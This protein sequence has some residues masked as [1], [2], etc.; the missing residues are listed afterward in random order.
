ME[1]PNGYVQV[2]TT[3]ALDSVDVGGK[4]RWAI[5]VYDDV[6]GR[7][8]GEPWHIQD[9][10]MGMRLWR[11][12]AAAERRRRRLQRRSDEMLLIADVEDARNG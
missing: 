11:T 12:R 5:R 4:I 3:Y 6:D 2:N 7:P 1:A 10:Y 9:R 8:F